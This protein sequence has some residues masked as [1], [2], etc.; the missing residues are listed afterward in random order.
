MSTFSVSLQQIIDQFALIPVTKEDLISEITITTADVN[1]PG[2]QL[3][4]FMEFFGYNRIQVM[5]NAEMAYLRSLTKSERTNRLDTIFKTQFPCM[6]VARRLE[7]FPEMIEASNKYC[8]PILT[9]E[10]YTS[11]FIS[12]LFRYLN[13]H[14]APRV[15]THGVLVE[16]YGE[17]ILIQGES[18]VGKSETALEIVK[19]GHRLIADDLVEIRRVSDTTLLGNAPDI[20]R[21]FIEIR[22]IGLL[23]VKNL[24]GV[25]SVKMQENVNLVINLEIWDREKN[26]ERIGIDEEYTDILGIKVPSHTIPVRPGRNLAIIVEVAAMNY[27]QREMGY[28][29]AR[30]L[31]DRA[32]DIVG[33]SD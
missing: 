32:F 9:T 21:H 12:G 7:I 19:R 33:D 10:D 24:Y 14:L 26:Y 30:H 1:R 18:G 22:G 13:V 15:T 3:T 11:A 8:V 23:D 4:G 27:R 17:G 6:V 2:L 31:V 20:I 16:V 5:G 28:N 25:G 29:A